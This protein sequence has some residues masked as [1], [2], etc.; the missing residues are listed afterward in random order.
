MS[1]TFGAFVDIGVKTDG[2]VHV[3]QLADKL[4]KPYGSRFSRGRGESQ[5]H[6]RRQRQK[7]DFPFYEGAQIA[8]I[9]LSQAKTQR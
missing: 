7:E 9:V 6:R 2:L 4:S 1:L 8:G 3:S 5:N